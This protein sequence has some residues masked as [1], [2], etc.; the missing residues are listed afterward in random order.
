LPRIEAPGREV[1]FSPDGQIL[2]TS[3][4]DSTVKLW[5]VGDGKLLRTL[6]HPEGVTSIA[7][8]PD[9]QQLVSGSYDSKVRLWRMSMERS[10]ARL[11]APREPS[12]P[13]RSVRTAPASHR[14][15]KTTK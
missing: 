10:A 8:S 14:V 13:S 3:S 5:R 15:A 6:Q 12:G 7:F 4:V 1:A 11:Q 9:G 2:A